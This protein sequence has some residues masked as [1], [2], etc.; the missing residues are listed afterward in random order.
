[1]AT[2]VQLGSANNSVTPIEEL[3]R[4]ESALSRLV[5]AYISTGLAFMLLPG[6]FLGVWNLIHIS[7]HSAA[8]SPS[9]IQAHGHAQVFGWVGTFILGIGFYSI[10][11]MRKQSGF[12]L[13]VAWSCY[14]LW[15]TGVLLRWFANVY[16]YGWR[17]LLPVSA[18]M[19]LAAFALFLRAV[20]G[21]RAPPK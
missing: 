21:H 5:M 13:S 6:T 20:A 1:M 16:L 10:P 18:S 15:T 4:R 12:A 19:E 11:K 8:I 7:R 14:A 17:I 2:L 3:R 9:W